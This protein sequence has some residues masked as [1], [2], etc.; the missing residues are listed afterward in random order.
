MALCRLLQSLPSFNREVLE[1]VMVSINEPTVLPSE[2]ELFRHRQDAVTD[3]TSK[4][5]DVLNGF[6]LVE[7]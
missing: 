7:G 6:K 4:S 3:C 2:F 5:V 1:S